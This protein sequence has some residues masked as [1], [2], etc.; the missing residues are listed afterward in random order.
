MIPWTGAR[1]PRAWQR[2]ALEAVVDDWIAGEDA[3]VVSAVMGAGK[4]ALIAELCR[5]AVG[6]GWRVV[7]TVPSQA[8][9]RQ[10]AAAV[11]VRV[12]DVGTWYQ[13]ARD[14]RAVTVAC[15]DS[16]PGLPIEAPDL[17][18]ADE[19]HGTEAP[20]VLAWA[21]RARPVRRL[22][23]SATPYRADVRASLRLW[24]HE[25][26]RYDAADAIRDG[27]LVPWRL[28]VPVAGGDLDEACTAWVSART[29]PGIVSAAS[30]D[31]AE[32]YAAE[33]CDAGVPAMAVHSRMGRAAVDARI[34]ALRTGEVRALVHVA[35]LVEGV[36]LPWL[37]WLALRRRRG[38]RVAFAQEVGR[39][40]RA[41]PGK[42]HADVWDPWGAFAEHGLSDPAAL[43][44]CMR[45]EVRERAEVVRVPLVDALTG[46]VFDAPLPARERRKIVETGAAVAWVREACAALRTMGLARPEIEARD[47]GWRLRGATPGQLA[48]LE[49]WGRFARWAA[50]DASTRDTPLRDMARAWRMVHARG[51]RARAGIV[52]D[53]LAV[54]IAMRDSGQRAAVAGAL[55]RFGVEWRSTDG[56]TN[57][58]DT[59]AA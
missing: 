57:E 53:L 32:G 29:G 14:V 23:M 28:H 13:Y 44:E 34:D 16:L 49:R 52:S 56:E 37:R 50:H 27:V 51:S 17:W 19:A 24:S 48:L 21:E 33:L 20:A 47:R 3:G 9:V 22:G 39:V 11:A 45:A 46:E 10:T 59:A 58:A 5:L 54:I 35:M 26:Y 25:V 38:S 42:T 55:A 43:G 8:L 31:D 1:E 36:D 18:I 2:A 6:W 12:D 40:L 30:I 15:V 41:A 7:V 4:S